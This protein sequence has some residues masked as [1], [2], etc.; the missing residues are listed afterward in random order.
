[1]M[2]W[3]PFT[4]P[5]CVSLSPTHLY[6]NKYRYL[7]T[8]TSFLLRTLTLFTLP[9]T[10]TLSPLILHSTSL[11]CRSMSCQRDV[12]QAISAGRH[13]ST[14]TCTGTGL[15]VGIS[16]SIIIITCSSY[17]G[18]CRGRISHPQVSYL[19]LRLR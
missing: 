17:P 15:W 12:C 16:I 1:M 13:Q 2:Q 6:M 18:T 4:S 8:R 19:L 3:I 7:H 9:H 14:C 11:L 10:L 5:R